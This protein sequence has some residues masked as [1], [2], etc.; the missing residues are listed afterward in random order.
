[1]I[2]STISRMRATGLLHVIE[3]RFSMCGRICEP[4][5]STNRPPDIR[6]SR[7]AI[8]ARSMGLRANTIAMFVKSVARVVCSP[9]R[10]SG[11]NGSCGPSAVYSPSKPMPSSSRAIVGTFGRSDRR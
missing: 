2:A 8:C 9:A 10:T 1:M 7:S 11:K 5:P 4:R 3:K 6:C